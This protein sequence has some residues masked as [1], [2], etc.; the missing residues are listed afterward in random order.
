MEW[1]CSLLKGFLGLGNALSSSH[2]PLW[3]VIFDSACSLLSYNFCLT[4]GYRSS[5]V[6]AIIAAIPE[7]VL[8]SFAGAGEALLSIVANFIITLTG[9]G[10]N[11]VEVFVG[12]EVNNFRTFRDLLRGDVDCDVFKNYVCHFL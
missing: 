11:L 12:L 3:N 4:T 10:L 9:A 7:A 5:D 8:A 1:V 2:N 6:P